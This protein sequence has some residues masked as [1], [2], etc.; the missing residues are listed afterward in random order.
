MLL[1]GLVP[2]SKP[3]YP[4][5]RFGLIFFYLPRRQQTAPSGRK[6]A[7]PAAARIPGTGT[8]GKAPASV[9]TID[10]SDNEGDEDGGGAAQGISG[11]QRPASNQQ[12]VQADGGEK[13]P[14]RAGS[15]G[16]RG[17]ATPVVVAD[18]DEDD[19]EEE[20]REEG[21]SEEEEHT[22]PAEV[23]DEGLGGKGCWSGVPDYKKPRGS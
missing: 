19:D 3:S 2:I 6:A 5:S 4:L 23:M 1:L 9:I 12:R 7:G 21:T 10:N 20:E 14:A 22:P 13:R 16:R 8:S 11:W 18:D 17:P 15:S